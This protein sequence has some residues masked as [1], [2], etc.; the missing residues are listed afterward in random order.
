MNTFS[1]DLLGLVF[2]NLDAFTP[3]QLAKVSKDFSTVAYS[4]DVWLEVHGSQRRDTMALVAAM[5]ADLNISRAMLVWARKDAIDKIS[6]CNSNPFREVNTENYVRHLANIAKE[7]WT[8]AE[9]AVDTRELELSI[10]YRIL[11]LPIKLRNILCKNWAIIGPQ[12]ES[13][14][15]RIKTWAGHDAHAW[16]RREPPRRS[17]AKMLEVEKCCAIAV[18]LGFP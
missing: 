16:E 18:R 10:A 14:K 6:D 7:Q 2:S 4:D 5:V 3:C 11:G 12:V 1:L 17:L 8:K 9:R 15:Y 13:G